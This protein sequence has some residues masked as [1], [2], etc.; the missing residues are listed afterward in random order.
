MSVLDQLP[1]P[2]QL[3][4]GAA[5]FGIIF[6]IGHSVLQLAKTVYSLWAILWGMRRVDVIDGARR[7]LAV[8]F[9]AA[10]VDTQLR[11]AGFVLLGVLR[12][13]YPRINFGAT[14]HVRVSEDELT[15]ASFNEIAPPYQRTV[16]ATWFTD[17]SVVMTAYPMGASIETPQLVYQFVRGSLAAALAYHQR[18]VDEWLAQGRTP[19]KTADIETVIAQQIYFRE[20]Y[21]PLL[22][23][24]ARTGNLLLLVPNIT[25]IVGAIGLVIAIYKA[26]V[27]W[28]IGFGVLV[29]LAL[30]SR[31]TLLRDMMRRIREPSGAADD[32]PDHITKST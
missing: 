27:L 16:L 25:V 22:P 1:V 30:W 23:Q 21:D 9:A 28:S 3:L 8:P 15:T 4:I 7:G 12:R 17:N 19:V 18:R 13:E 31:G 24:P 10:D 6:L 2:L 29:A 32:E 14:L 20:H 5:T 11:D 26:E